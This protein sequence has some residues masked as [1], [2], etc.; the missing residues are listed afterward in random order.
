MALCAALASAPSATQRCV[1]LA[2]SAAPELSSTQLALA[3]A[4]ASPELLRAL[5]HATEPS[6][7]I[8]QAL[9][10]DDLLCTLARTHSRRLAFLSLP[11]DIF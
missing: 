8:D 4:A 5:C 1:D 6:A 9:A 11:Q 7:C 2:R 3:T 10:E